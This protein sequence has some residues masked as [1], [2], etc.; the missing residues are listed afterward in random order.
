[1]SVKSKAVESTP[2]I[3]LSQSVA[4]EALTYSSAEEEEAERKYKE[5]KK[6]KKKRRKKSK[7]H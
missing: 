6:R 5:K 4:A 1:M 7:K 2:V 3:G